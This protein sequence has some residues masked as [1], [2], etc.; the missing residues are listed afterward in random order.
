MDEVTLVDTAHTQHSEPDGGFQPMV[1]PDHSCVISTVSTK[2][3]EVMVDF[4][5]LE[6]YFAWVKQ[7][8][9]ARSG[10]DLVYK[11]TLL[12]IQN[13][14]EG[15]ELWEKIMRDEHRE[16]YTLKR[17]ID[18]KV[19]SCFHRAVFFNLLMQQVGIPSQIME[20]RLV[21]TRR[22]NV[23]ELIAG[24][25]VL[26]GGVRI[27]ESEPYEEHLWNIVE[28]GGVKYLVDT[29]FLLDGK[30]VIQPISKEGVLAYQVV[31]ISGGRRKLYVADAVS[32][33]EI[34]TT[35]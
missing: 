25:K 1:I 28:I 9:G 23:T 34:E 4:A 7:Q 2:P 10:L 27:L 33:I 3:Q 6:D 13:L 29:S 15:V 12:T 22:E 20:G 19:I 24:A 8:A 11:A 14:K 35:R 26:K 5:E 31:M 21:E 17:C 18:E 16:N 30:A 32:G